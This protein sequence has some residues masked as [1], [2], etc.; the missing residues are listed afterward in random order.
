MAD[1]LKGHSNQGGKA[2]LPRRHIRV[3]K[4]E[5]RGSATAV[6]T[7]QCVVQSRQGS[8]KVTL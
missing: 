5:N 1:F 7:Q 2:M 3:A 8:P 6:D 4:V